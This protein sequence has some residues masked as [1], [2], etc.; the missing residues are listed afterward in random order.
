M[1]ATTEASV[2]AQTHEAPKL[3]P[4]VLAAVI[5]ETARR[6]EAR[7]ARPSPIHLK[8][9]QEIERFAEKAAKSGMV[10]KDYIG[11]PDAICIAVQMGSELGLAPMQALQNI[12]V[13]NGRPSI[14]GDAMLALVKASPLCADIEEHSEGDGDAMVAVCVAKRVGKKPVVHRFSVD[15]A[16]RANLWKTEPKVKKQGRDGPYEVDAG[17]WYSYPQRMLQMR[18]RGFAL[19]DAFPDVLKGLLSA[20]EARDIPWEDTGL[21]IVP[22][23]ATAQPIRPAAAATPRADRVVDP[24]VYDTPTPQPQKLSWSQWGDSLEV[25]ARETPDDALGRVL[26]RAEVGEIKRLAEQGA[27]SPAKARILEAIRE[28]EERYNAYVKQPS[29]DL[30]GADADSATEPAH[31]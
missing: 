2:Q 27:Y 15:D 19:R 20:E 18:A 11:R 12:A 17:P 24:T 31:A 16:K 3:N 7:A 21:S 4:D 10:P 23:V 14:W 26:A 22:P 13:I 30:P 1:S 29:D 28:M 5:E 9:W 25:T 8:S 6:I